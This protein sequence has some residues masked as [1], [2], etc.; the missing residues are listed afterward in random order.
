MPTG[1]VAQKAD[2]IETVTVTAAR[3]ALI[4]SAATSSQ[5]VVD[6]QELSLLPVFRP[7]QLLETVPGLTVTSH[8]GEGKANQYLLRGFNLDHGTDLGVFLDGMPVN[9][10]S[11]AHGQG[12]TDLNFLIPEIAQ[13][14]SFTKGPYF[15]REGDFSSVGSIHTS[16]VDTIDNQVS[17]TIG[18]LGYQRGF[19][20]GSTMLGD[21]TLL[22][23]GELVHY[24]GPW[25]HPDNFR[26]ANGMLRY[27]SGDQ[28]NGFSIT[29]MYYRGLWNATTDQPV[30]AITAGL[31]GRYGTL[32]PSDG[33]QAQRISLTG[34]YHTDLGDGHLDAN[35]YAINNRLTLW[36]DFT[37]FQDDP[38]NGDQEGQN[39]LRGTFGGAVTYTRSDTLLGF[40]NDLLAG[41]SNRYDENHVFR[42]HTKARVS[43][44][45]FEDDTLNLD[46]VAGYVQATTHWTSWFRTVLGLREDAVFGSDEGTNAGHASQALLQPKGSLIFTP[47][48]WLEVYFSAG[49]G[50]HSDDLRGVNQAASLHVAGAPLISQQRG[51]EL[52]IR[53]NIL[54]N[55]TATLTAFYLK[56]QSETK[57]DADAGQDSAGPG[58]RRSGLELNTTWQALSWLE[59]YT[60]VA[61][62]HAR[63]TEP[64]DDGDGKH[65]G[66]HIPEAPGMIGSL[67]AYIKDLDGWSG[68]LA[69]RYLGPDPVVPDNSIRGEGYGEWNLDASYQFENGWKLGAGLYNALDTRAEGADFY[70]TDR[71]PGE[72]PGGV[73]DLHVHPLEPRTIRITIGKLL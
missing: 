6:R 47:V 3:T 44:S 50:F 19:A 36:N 41:F 13:G 55:L 58:S 46:D 61:A 40:E 20:S 28:Q 4:G 34:Q 72:A 43:L 8:S 35:L 29:G 22:A 24:D 60:T 16:V 27:V 51:E 1:A 67:S 56:S 48:K 2:G 37:H 49:E 53:T 11:H 25:T 33:G 63:Y 26:K 62:S 31:I 68:A 57:Y 7:A 5:G 21:A 17:T 66:E 73:G 9:E 38:V 64:T 30:R 69:Y 14:V 15:A 18:T 71:L 32:D 70:Y 65:I 23:A 12:Y 45:L 52:G 10:P 59:F 54:P 39:E 42:N